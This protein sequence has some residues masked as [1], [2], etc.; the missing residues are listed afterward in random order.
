[1]PTKTYV[2]TVS[3]VP[4][5][6]NQLAINDKRFYSARSKGSPC[7]LVFVQGLVRLAKSCLLL[8]GYI[9]LLGA[10]QSSSER[11]S[12]PTF[13]TTVVSSSGFRGEIYLIAPETSSLPNFKHRT[14][15]GT[16]YTTRLNVPRRDFREGFPG[17]TNRVEWFAIDYIGRFW[18]E[19]AGQY[20]FG[21][22]SD[23][24]SK[25]YIDHHLVIDDDGQHPPLGCTG[26]AELAPG[27]HEIRVPYFQGPGGAVAL[28]LI[29]QRPGESW[30]VFDTNEFKPP[31]DS[32]AW[33]SS[34]S[35][36]SKLIRKVKAGHCWAQ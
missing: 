19:H 34:D 14:P 28:T 18:V 24:G 8:I 29:V 4:G 11:N 15:V 12:V 32:T 25:L 16:I 21:L 23:D 1:M 22:S 2:V 30:R 27:I 35:E 26:T 6:I 20:G 33:T 10:E 3:K 17:V 13:G 7:S 9:Y 5:I 36:P 31:A